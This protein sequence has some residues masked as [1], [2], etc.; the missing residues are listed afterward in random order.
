[1]TEK[2]STAAFRERVILD[3][4]LYLVIVYVTDYTYRATWRCGACS[5]RSELA[6]AGVTANAAIAF[7]KADLASHQAKLHTRP[8][9]Q[10]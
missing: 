2:H 4:V 10:N 5:H 9:R 3:G 8:A 7:A 6:F 1:M